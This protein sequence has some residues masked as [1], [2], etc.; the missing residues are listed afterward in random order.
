MADN[1]EDVIE[2]KIPAKFDKI[3]YNKGQYTSDPN[4]F[5]SFKNEADRLGKSIE[6]VNWDSYIF[7]NVY[8][9]NEL[10]EKEFLL[11]IFRIRLSYKNEKPI[12]SIPTP[13]AKDLENYII[14]SKYSKSSKKNIYGF[15]ASEIYKKRCA[16]DLNCYFSH[17]SINHPGMFFSLIFFFDEWEEIKA[18]GPEKYFE[19]I[20]GPLPKEEPS[21]KS[22]PSENTNSENN[23]TNS[24]IKSVFGEAFKEAGKAFKD[25]FKGLNIFGK[26]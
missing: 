6:D 21:S 15:C 8:D 2:F 24:D 22:V 3:C 4:F 1:D 9:F 26:K 19:E 5:K 17:F 11:K 10:I 7:L 16:V 25:S 20:Y 23:S 14:E 13:L 12:E 18:K